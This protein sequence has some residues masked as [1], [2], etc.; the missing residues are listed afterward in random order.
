MVG[1]GEGATWRFSGSFANPHIG[2]REMHST[3]GTVL[4]SYGAVGFALFAVTMALIFRPAPWAHILYSLPIWA[5]G[6]THQGLRFATFWVFFA[7]VFGTA[8]YLAGSR[9]AEAAPGRAP[10]IDL[11]SP[12]LSPRLVAADRRR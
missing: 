10:V 4:F 2:D 12:S 1:A 5:Y 3:L 8:H 9:P 11:R 6:V 7:L